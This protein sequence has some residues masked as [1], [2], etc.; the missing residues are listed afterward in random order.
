MELL[1]IRLEPHRLPTSRSPACSPGHKAMRDVH[2]LHVGKC[3]GTQ[4]K[5]LAASINAMKAG[6]RI[7][8]HPQRITPAILPRGEA[9]VFSIRSPETKVLPGFSS[10]K[11]KGQPG[12]KVEW[13]AGE[14][15]AFLNFDHANDLAEALFTKGPRRWQAIA[16]IRAISDLAANRCDYF[17]HCSAFL[18]SRRP[19]RIV[20]QKR[21]DHEI[22]LLF[23]K[24]QLSTPPL[25][26]T[27]PVETHKNDHTGLMPLSE[28]AKQK[29]RICYAQDFEL[30]RHCSDW[31]ES[32]T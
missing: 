3:A 32:Q 1:R 19:L 25:M 15:E 12:F 10:H 5:A 28:Q 23:R 31:L 27:D 9:R 24:V 21:F 29:L 2:F 13:T 8:A 30:Y 6:I 17:R 7:V 16:A 18:A 14:R 11:R 20:R 22:G 4:T 26:E